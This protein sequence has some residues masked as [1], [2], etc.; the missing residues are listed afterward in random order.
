[1]SSG[2]VTRTA[3]A[4]LSIYAIAV[5]WFA[6]QK[7][8]KK[9]RRR[10]N[11]LEPRPSQHHDQPAPLEN[12]ELSPT[13]RT[14]ATTIPNGISNQATADNVAS[15]DRMLGDQSA[16]VNLLYSLTERQAKQG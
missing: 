16:L 1:M 13:L 10:P 14:T 8:G 6:F 4:F 2:G 15:P 9:R 3:I 7:H 5:T 11:E 12:T